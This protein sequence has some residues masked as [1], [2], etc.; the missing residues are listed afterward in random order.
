MVPAFN[1]WMFSHAKGDVGLVETQFGFHIMMIEDTFSAREFATIAKLIEPSQATESAMFEK[2][3]SFENEIAKGKNFT[4]FAKENEY[5]IMNGQKLK[6]GGDVIP[7]LVGNNA[8]IVNWT[9]EEGVKKGDVKKFEIT[10]AYVVAA[11]TN[12]EEKGLQSVS[13]AK[14][15]A[16]PAILNNKKAA[17][18]SKKLD[19]SLKEIAA[20]ENVK[21]QN[22]RDLSFNKPATSI[23]GRDKIVV[24]TLLGMKEGEVVRGVQGSNGVYALKLT[25]KV[26]PGELSTYEPYRKQL[27]DKLKKDNNKIYQALKDISEIES[28]R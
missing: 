5:K 4:E 22:T 15:K 28:F 7:G 24:G 20:R 18:L 13:G 11:I 6:K 3:A 21:V 25:S 12:V 2:A 16:R 26:V 23:L 19:G 14:A 17:I 27:N 1:D 9:F 8:Q 10:K